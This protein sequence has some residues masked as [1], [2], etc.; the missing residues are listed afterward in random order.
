MWLQI[1][2]WP[3]RHVRASWEGQLSSEKPPQDSTPYRKQRK[4][5]NTEMKAHAYTEAHT[6]T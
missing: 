2:Y 6:Y 5:I 3:W 4:A 1:A